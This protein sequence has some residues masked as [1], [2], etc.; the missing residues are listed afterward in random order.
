MNSHHPKPKR[1]SALL[2]TLLVVSLLLVLVTAF[3]V[4]VRMEF[5][6][7]DSHQNLHIARANAR[8]G[9]NL[10]V[11]ELQRHAGAD[12]RV[13]ATAGILDPNPNTPAVGTTPSGNYQG[14]Q[15]PYWTGVWL[16]DTPDSLPWESGYNPHPLAGKSPSTP[17]GIPAWLVSG[18]HAKDPDHPDYQTPTNTLYPRPGSGDEYVWML[19][20]PLNPTTPVGPG[21]PLS[22]SRRI[23]AQVI[24]V[25]PPAGGPPSRFAYHVFDEGVKVSLTPHGTDDHSGGALIA[26][27]GAVEKTDAFTAITPEERDSLNRISGLRQVPLALPTDPAYDPLSF[28]HTFTSVAYGVQ[29]DTA[30]GGLKRDL[31][32]AFD[33]PDADFNRSPLFAE[34]PIQRRDGS[35]LFNGAGDSALP[36][37][38]HTWAPIHLSPMR[39]RSGAPENAIWGTPWHVLRDY[40]RLY[41]PFP[42]NPTGHIGSMGDAPLYRAHPFSFGDPGASASDQSIRAARIAQS[43]WHSSAGETNHLADSVMVGS[44]GF[45]YPYKHTRGALTPVV[46]KFVTRWSIQVDEEIDPLDPANRKRLRLVMQPSF[47]LWNPYNVALE[48]D[49]VQ[50]YF[51]PDSGTEFAVE[52]ELEE[53]VLD[54]PYR[55]QQE[56]VHNGEVYR[57][58]RNFSASQ[59]EPLP[60]GTAEWQRITTAA[61]RTANGR[62]WG[63]GALS[64]WERILA[65]ARWWAT[66]RWVLVSEGTTVNRSGN[67]LLVRNFSPIRFEPGEV[68]FFGPYDN[69]IVEGH[70][71]AY[72]HEFGRTFLLQEG[73]FSPN[74]GIAY[75]RIRTDLVNQDSSLKPSHSTVKP[76][77][78]GTDG[79]LI[80]DGAREVRVSMGGF[81]MGGRARSVSGS[82]MS[83]FYPRE[84]RWDRTTG[85][86]GVH[87][88]GFLGLARSPTPNGRRVFVWDNTDGNRSFVPLQFLDTNFNIRFRYE[89][90]NQWHGA[91]PPMDSRAMVFPERNLNAVSVEPGGFVLGQTEYYL[92]ADDDSGEWPFRVFMNNPRMVSHNRPALVNRFRPG[93]SWSPGLGYEDVHNHI[94]LLNDDTNINPN[95]APIQQVGG[96]GFYG[97]SHGPSGEHHVMLFD[98]PRAPLLSLGQLQHAAMTLGG[99]TPA[100]VI[101]N[102]EISPYVASG[103][104]REHN[105][106]NDYHAIRTSN[107]PRRSAIAADHS[108]LLNEALFDGF[109]FSSLLPWSDSGALS[110]WVEGLLPASNPRMLSLP[111]AELVNLDE[112]DSYRHSASVLHTAGSFNVN[113]VSKDAWKALFA[114]LNEARVP[115]IQGIHESSSAPSGSPLPR[116]QRHLDVE[117]DPWSGF[118]ALSDAELDAL[119]EEMVREVKLRGPFLSLSDFVNR[120][121][122]NAGTEPGGRTVTETGLKGALQRAIDRSGVNSGYTAI[123]ESRMALYN[124]IVKQSLISFPDMDAFIGVEGSNKTMSHASGY[125]TQA[126]ILQVI[127]P[128]ISARSDTFRI[129]FYGDTRPAGIH[130]PLQARVYGEALVRRLPAY[131]HDDDPPETRPYIGSNNMTQDDLQRMSPLPLRKGLT[132]SLDGPRYNGSEIQSVEVE[133]NLHPVNAAFGRRFEIVSF[134]WLNEDEI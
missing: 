15:S 10:A 115:V 97:A 65:S 57:Y 107:H 87:L 67:N 49:A 71:S 1:G 84:I 122:V 51:R 19:H 123:N 134:R 70:D 23:L 130:Q 8:L 120:R 113:S 66:S 21:A 114:S 12:Q 59:E 50:F 118:R 35:L 101:G 99:E 129:R 3:T 81:G 127:A 100:Y 25:N 48:V 83:T 93:Q 98:I 62:V 119:A 110:D 85:N 103:I 22:D 28:A 121:L 94:Q 86:D 45:D 111:G 32:I 61:S 17:K 54:V 31:S 63:I 16:A 126:D 46:S 30:N 6:Q 89:Y 56:V 117:N 55:F 2:I 40:A 77:L 5:R 88:G 102:S 37:D 69:T 11:A 91:V 73:S 34:S 124:S 105:M 72:Y 43:F 29:S 68:K 4:F 52:T 24:T 116:G 53:W 58:R 38:E 26:R 60:E 109:F 27:R 104:E 106:R 9:L 76:L 33:M 108:W 92:K 44:A 82:P 47:T 20:H 39:Q 133:S 95:L 75:D 41:L 14:V 128:S 42:Q 112:A 125:L 18:N 96:K 132:L 74:S 36:Q 7:I 78:G 80:L 131:V 90:E 64:N 79:E 13:T